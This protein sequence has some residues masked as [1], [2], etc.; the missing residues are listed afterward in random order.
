M[1]DGPVRSSQSRHGLRRHDPRPDEN[2]LAIYPAAAN[3]AQGHQGQ[4]TG[5]HQMRRGTRGAAA[6]ALHNILTANGDRARTMHTVAARTD[7]ELLS[8]GV[9][10]VL[11]RNDQRLVRRGQAWRQHVAR[12]RRAKPHSSGSA[13]LGHQAR[14]A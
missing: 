9:A 10:A 8:S 7:R 1:L 14:R 4:D 12:T 6:H 3:E 5:I 2:R 11:D 13:P